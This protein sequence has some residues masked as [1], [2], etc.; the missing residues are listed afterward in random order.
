MLGISNVLLRM[1]VKN[2]RKCSLVVQ[3]L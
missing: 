2:Y 3:I 1:V